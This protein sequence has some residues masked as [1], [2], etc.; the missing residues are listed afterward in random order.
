MLLH[1]YIIFKEKTSCKMIY[2][3]GMIKKW[4]NTQNSTS[5][6]MNTYPYSKGIKTVAKIQQQ[7]HS[8]YL[9]GREKWSWDGECRDFQVFLWKRGISE[10][11]Q[12]QQ[13]INISLIYVVSIWMKKKDSLNLCLKYITEWKGEV[14]HHYH[15]LTHFIGFSC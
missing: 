4:L 11:K 7:F 3:Y 13:N 9:W 8:S 15:M 10:L 14:E 6:L 1:K 12:I 2:I 5:W